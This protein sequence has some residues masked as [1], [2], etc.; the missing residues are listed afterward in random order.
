MLDA[1]PL[2]LQ[3]GTAY[4][5]SGGASNRRADHPPTLRRIIRHCNTPVRSQPTIQITTE[6]RRPYVYV[7]SAFTA[8]AFFCMNTAHITEHTATP[9]QQT[10]AVTIAQAGIPE[11]KL[12]AIAPAQYTVRHDDTLWIISD[13]H[14]ERPYHWLRLWGMSHR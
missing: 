2:L 8:A 6:V 7:L 9:M 12:P 5:H 3:R 1:V 14:L 13:K 11:T 10:R 4:N